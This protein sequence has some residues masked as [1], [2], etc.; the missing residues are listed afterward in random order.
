MVH[1]LVSSEF[2]ASWPACGSQGSRLA[3]SATRPRPVVVVVSFSSTLPPPPPPPP[4]LS[5]EAAVDGGN[6]EG[7]NLDFYSA[8]ACP[9]QP[10]ISKA[11][12]NTSSIFFAGHAFVVSI[13]IKLRYR[14]SVDAAAPRASR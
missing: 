5:A 6:P 13:P 7:H 8:I 11:E 12:F 14:K 1:S 2:F 10:L 4:W 3:D 9:Q